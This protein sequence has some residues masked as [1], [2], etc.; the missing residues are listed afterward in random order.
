L[1]SPFHET[2]VDLAEN[3]EAAQT[4][5]RDTLR[6]C[7]QESLYLTTRGLNGSARAL[8]AETVG[9]R[10][11]NGQLKKLFDE[12]DGEAAADG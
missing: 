4:V 10:V 7:A 11:L 3:A 2:L 12:Q 6:R 9:E 1:E 5:W 8:K